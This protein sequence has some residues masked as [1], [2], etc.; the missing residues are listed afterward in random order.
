MNADTNF[1]KWP[2]N[3]VYFY[4][5]AGYCEYWLAGFDGMKWDVARNINSVFLLANTAEQDKM[6]IKL[7]MQKVA[8]DLNGCIRFQETSPDDPLYKVKITPTSDL[9]GA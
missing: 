2:G 7:A 5:D 1:L 3:T 9:P 8:S 6:L 4:I